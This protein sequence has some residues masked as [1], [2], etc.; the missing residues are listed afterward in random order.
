MTFEEYLSKKGIT[1]LPWQKE[2]SDAFLKVMY[3]NKGSAA[4]KIFLLDQLYDFI[5]RYGNAFEIK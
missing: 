3:C 2:A 4:G 5:E 1:L